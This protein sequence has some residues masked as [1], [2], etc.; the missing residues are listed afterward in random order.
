MP[1]AQQLEASSGPLYLVLIAGKEMSWVKTHPNPS[2]PQEVHMA[3]LM[4][5]NLGGQPATILTSENRL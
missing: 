5:A 1:S 3:D 4:M 2:L